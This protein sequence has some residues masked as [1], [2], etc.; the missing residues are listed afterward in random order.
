MVKLWENKMMGFYLFLL[1]LVLNQV[2]LKIQHNGG[3]KFITFN[4][5]LY[6]NYVRN[7]IVPQLLSKLYGLSCHV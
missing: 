4:I 7:L 3:V 2:E 1:L 6:Y 5:L